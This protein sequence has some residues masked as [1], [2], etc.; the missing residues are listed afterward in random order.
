MT[1]TSSEPSGSGSTSAS[2]SVSAKSSAPTRVVQLNV[3]VTMAERKVW[4][5]KRC[6]CT[7][8]AGLKAEQANASYPSNETRTAQ[9]TAYNFVFLNLFYQFS[10]IA[11]F[12][13]LIV[14]ILSAI[15]QI[16]PIHPW[17]SFMPLV[18]VVLISMVREGIEDYGRHKQDKEVNRSTAHVLVDGVIED[19]E[20]RW[21]VVGDIVQL[22]DDGPVPADL[23]LLATS[24]EDGTASVETKNL[25]GENNL[26]TKRAIRAIH[27]ASKDADSELEY[28][29]GF[30]GTVETSMPVPDLQEFTGTMTNVSGFDDPFSVSH[31]ELLLRGSILRGTKSI[32]AVVVFSGPDTKEMRNKISRPP[33]RT[34]VDKLMTR[35]ILLILALLGLT[36]IGAAVAASF[37]QADNGAAHVY[38]G[39]EDDNRGFVGFKAF[40]TFFILL[41]TLV[42]ISLIVSIEMVKV[43]HMLQVNIDPDMYYAESEIPARARTSNL[44]EEL[45][46]ISYVFSDKTGTLTENVMRFQKCAIAGVVYGHSDVCHDAILD[47]AAT[48]SS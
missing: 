42:P 46:Q 3:P 31:E 16:S 6:S 21:L 39:L 7:A 1:T 19:I 22:L 36:L 14:A 8:A 9:Y 33:K 38:L 41:S 13:F 32:W 24:A 15:P 4:N 40:F 10:R 23:V 30:S 20:W 34:H 44:S 5:S 43:V 47:P 35:C 27:D 48:T 18:T 11:N 37:W 45:G 25:D 28:F 29:A 17:S 26:K 2:G 12:Y